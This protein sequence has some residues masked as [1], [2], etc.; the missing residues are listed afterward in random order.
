MVGFLFLDI[1]K[2]RIAELTFTDAIKEVAFN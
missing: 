2:S 1:P